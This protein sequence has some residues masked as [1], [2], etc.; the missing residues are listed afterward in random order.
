M[1]DLNE[2][3]YG[4]SGGAAV[5]MSVPE[6]VLPPQSPVSAPVAPA[7]ASQPQAPQ[8]QAPQATVPQA[9][10]PQPAPQESIG[11]FERLR[12]DPVFSQAALMAGLRLAQGPRPGQSP[13]GLVADAMLVGK[14]AHDMLQGNIVRD[15]QTAETHKANMARSAAQTEGQQLQNEETKLTLPSKVSLLKSKAEALER[16]GEVEKAL[17]VYEQAKAAFKSFIAKTDTTGI[18]ERATMQELLIPSLESASK[19]SLQEAQATSAYA[20]ANNANAHAALTKAQMENPEKFNKGGGNTSAQIQAAEY[21]GEQ[22]KKQGKTEAEITRA[23]SD[24]LT[25]SKTKSEYESFVHW[26]GVAGIDISTPAKVKEAMGLYNTTKEILGGTPPEV[27]ATT[28]Q[29]TAGPTAMQDPKAAAI[30]RLRATP[31]AEAYTIGNL[32]PNGWE[33]LD[34]TGK[35]VAYGR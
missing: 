24:Y 5:P 21:L 9:V 35:V 4:A 12:S 16:A 17:Q 1:A 3:L 20:S 34:K 25:Q 23:K 33:V 19:R 13:L 29:K 32:T 2:I 22:L 15:Q 11:L 27:P 10:A 30:A 28:P 14:T 18:I 31:G 26:A 8:P 7:I 6:G